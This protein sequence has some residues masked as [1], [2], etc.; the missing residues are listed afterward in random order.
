MEGFFNYEKALKGKVIF[1]AFG[2]VRG[3]LF[4]QDIKGYPAMIPGDG[5]VFGEFLKLKNFN[6]QISVCDKI[7]EYFGP[8]HQDNYYERRISEVELANG[9]TSS[10]WIYW[11]T[12]N[13]LNS[14]ENPVTPIPHGDWRE[15][16]KDVHKKC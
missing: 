15:F 7:E 9:K 8:N 1:R 16:Q 14:L 5:W 6:K 11:Y 10:A 3:L 2:K 4:H 12:R 13:D